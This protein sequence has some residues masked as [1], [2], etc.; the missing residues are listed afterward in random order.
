MSTPSQAI[1]NSSPGSTKEEDED[2]QRVIVEE[3]LGAGE[4]DPIIV[5]GGSYAGEQSYTSDLSSLSADGHLYLVALQPDGIALPLPPP[6]N[7]PTTH[8]LY[9]LYHLD[10]SATTQEPTPP[11]P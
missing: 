5:V 6:S 8:Y 3:N 2:D 4:D 7:L 11:A 9:H 1:S 10:L